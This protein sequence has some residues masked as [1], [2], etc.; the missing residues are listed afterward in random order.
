MKAIPYIIL[1][2]WIDHSGGRNQVLG[3]MG[4]FVFHI[5]SSN[6]FLGLGRLVFHSFK[7][8][9]GKKFKNH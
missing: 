6:Y 4:F 3:K 5:L 9:E 1:E 8:R 7:I 2:Y